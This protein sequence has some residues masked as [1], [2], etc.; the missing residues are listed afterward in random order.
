MNIN[1]NRRKF[2]S[3]KHNAQKGIV[4]ISSLIMLLVMTMIGVSAM[5][6]SALEERMS[7]NDMNHNKVFQAAESATELAISNTANL[8]GALNGSAVN[9]TVTM[10]DPTV[11]SEAEVEF[12]AKGPALGFEM[13]D[14]NSIVAYHFDVQGT[15][16]IEA[17]D[18]QAVTSSG[19]WV[20]GPDS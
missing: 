20:L 4:L 17:V 3:K 2:F 6:G 8:S 16:E 11:S 10:P 13:G 7:A 9:V 14:D 12:L 19:I 5:R 15:G 18:A 1:F